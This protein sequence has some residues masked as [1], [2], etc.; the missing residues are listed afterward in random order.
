MYY[1]KYKLFFLY[2]FIGFIHPSDSQIHFYACKMN[3]RTEIVQGEVQLSIL[4]S[5][6]KHLYKVF[7]SCHKLGIP[8]KFR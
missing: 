6:M 8:V 1:K 2:L 7:E 3:F 5:Y 4:F